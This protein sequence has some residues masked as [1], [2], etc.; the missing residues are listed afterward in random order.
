MLVLRNVP[1]ILFTESSGSGDMSLNLQI[2]TEALELLE[3]IEEIC[4]KIHILLTQGT[5]VSSEIIHELFRNIHTLKSLTHMA[6]LKLLASAIHEA[7]DLLDII[8]SEKICISFEIVEF[9]SDLERV[10][11]M[12]FAQSY[13]YVCMYF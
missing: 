4:S 9:L 6:D 5:Q 11:E 2:R 1:F 10:C 3:K 8:R 12:V 13:F 7:E